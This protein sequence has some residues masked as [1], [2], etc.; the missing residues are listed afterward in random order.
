MKSKRKIL[1]KIT[2]ILAWDQRGSGWI[3]L[4]SGMVQDVLVIGGMLKIWIPNIPNG[5]LLII[6]AIAGVLKRFINI[7]VGYYDFKKGIWKV[8]S[9]WNM[10]TEQVSPFFLELREHLEEMGDKLGIKS[11]FKKL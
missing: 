2:E 3:G 1:L 4:I 8:Q 11:K 5:T 6:L 7:A 9:E 10:K